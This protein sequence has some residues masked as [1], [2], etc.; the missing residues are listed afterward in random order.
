VKAEL[1]IL[2]TIILGKNWI[3]KC[4]EEKKIVDAI[5]AEYLFLPQKQ[6]KKKMLGSANYFKETNIFV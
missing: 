4:L 5:E 1:R 6:S 2:T 3:Q